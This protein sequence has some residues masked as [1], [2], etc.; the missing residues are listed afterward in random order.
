[1][2]NFQVMH[3]LEVESGKG[4]FM[5][6][7][8]PVTNIKVDFSHD[9]LKN[10]LITAQYK[11]KGR[12]YHE[13]IKSTQWEHK[14]KLTNLKLKIFNFNFNNM[15]I[16]LKFTAD[17]FKEVGYYLEEEIYNDAWIIV[18]IFG[19]LAVIGLSGYF[20]VKTNSFWWNEFNHFSN[21]MGIEDD[22]EEQSE[23]AESI[24]S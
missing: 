5:N 17:Y 1:M 24:K 16:N 7:P 8:H 12:S 19:T 21:L 9:Q 23:Q 3:D 10:Y 13:V 20:Y 15:N 22:E 11:K 14:E 2:D 4:V 6:L 18:S